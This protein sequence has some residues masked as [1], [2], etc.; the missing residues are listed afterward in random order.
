MAKH[1]QIDTRKNVV[2][3]TIIPALSVDVITC[4]GGTTWLSFILKIRC[5]EIVQNSTGE[6]AI[7]DQVGF[8]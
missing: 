1:N 5:Q 2:A 7:K 6:F 3:T 4:A 8:S